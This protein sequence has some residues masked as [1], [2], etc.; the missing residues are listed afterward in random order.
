MALVLTPSSQAAT[1]SMAAAPYLYFGWGNP[2][3]P[4]TV[5][6]ATGVK[7]FTLAF[8]L[9]TGGCSP[10]WDGARPLLGGF[11]A[12][13]IGQIRRA[14]GDVIPSIGGWSGH[15]LGERCPSAA[16][17]ANAYQKVIGAYRLKAIDVDIENTEFE[18]STAQQR[19]IDALK[20]IR[21]RNP[22]LKI[23]LTFGTATNGPDA[24]GQ[25][26]IRKGAAAGFR[27]DAWVIMPFDFGGHSGSMGQASIN[28][29]EGLKARLR[30]AYGISS[31]QAYRMMGISTMNGKTD[32]RDETITLA[33]FRLMRAYAEQHHLARFT[34]WAVNRDR[35]CGPGD[36]AQLTCSGIP[37]RPWDFT[38]IV[39][40]FSG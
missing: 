8:I 27:P 11:D 23:Y 15:K 5:M 39:A 28:A 18:S 30:S 12:A 25:R 3:S 9:S 38:R 40:G 34:F 33:D 31:D 24:A 22:G 6:A 13:R 26:L 35:P 17:L 2:P 19:V 21:S 16:L 4:T 10:A 14:G 1:G 20:V 32:E 36:D 29:A 7:W 37:Q